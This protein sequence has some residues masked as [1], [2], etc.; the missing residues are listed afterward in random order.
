MLEAIL[1]AVAIVGGVGILIGL[2]LGFAGKIFAV[3]VDEKEEAVRGVLPGNNC[4]GCGFA[5]CDALAKAIASGEAPV[6]ACPVGGNDVAQKIASIMGVEAGE[7]EKRV[8]FVRCSGTCDKAKLEYHYYG[9]TDCRQATTA[10][11][12]AGKSCASGC[13]GFG[14][15]VAV[16]PQNAIAVKDGVAVVNAELC[17]GC[18]QCVNVCPQKVI[19]MIPATAVVAV[20]CSSPLGGKEVKAVCGAGCIGCGLCQKNCPSEAITVENHLAH[21]DQTKCTG[22]GLCASKC[23][24]KIIKLL[25]K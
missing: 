2:L 13:L 8:A 12:N 9:A 18:G 25:Q 1:I 24:V 19:G 15:C 16:C 23:P 22:C 17:V 10:P 5:G 7:V 3:E 4:G 6:N 14:S 11:G 21:I 20:A